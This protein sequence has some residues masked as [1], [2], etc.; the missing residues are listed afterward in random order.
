LI[1]TSGEWL[2]PAV[3]DEA[4]AVFHCPVRD[5]YACSEFIYVA[6]ACDEGWL[7]AN[8]DWLILEPVDAGYAPVPPG[9]PSHTTLLTNLANRIQP[10]IRYDLGDSI[11]LRPEPCP[12]GNPLPALRVEGRRD[13]VLTFPTAGGATVQVLPMALATVVEI[14]PGVR[15]YQVIQTEP[16][17][18]TLRLEVLPGA[19]PSQVWQT[20][21]TRLGVFLAS[22]GLSG[23]V[24]RKTAESPR[25]DPRSGK[26]RQVWSEVGGD[27][28]SS[29]AAGAS[30]AT[31]PSKS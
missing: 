15:R 16:S 21:V 27:A 23:V 4:A 25:R 22:Q 30:P 28:L 9:Q 20:A 10:L 8:A 5:V 1:V 6:V 7:H 29:K 18:L 19:E 3:R 24:V 31:V 12:C 11:T 14:T 2:A 13:E 17:T 26:F